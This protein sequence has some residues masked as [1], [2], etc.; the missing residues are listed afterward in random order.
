MNPAVPVE[1]GTVQTPGSRDDAIARVAEAYVW[2]LPLLLTRRTRAGQL[3]AGG[4]P[5]LVARDRLATA[6]DRA[7]VAPNNDTLYASG[8]FALAAG[9]V[10]VEAE[11]MAPPDRYWSVMLLDAYTHVAYVCRRLH[12][13]AGARV[14]VTYD[15][16]TPPVTDRGA[17]VLTLGTPTVWVLVRV[18]VDGPGDLDAARAALARIRVT[19]PAAA[20]PPV[21]TGRGDDRRAGV[22]R[23][24][25]AAVA[26]DPP[27]AW[28]PAPPAGLAA[29]LADPPPDDV[30][31]E[32]ARAG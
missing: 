32:G 12:G 3:T 18:L 26:E 27:A 13:R 23:E 21:G 1:R 29:L 14:R 2:G 24:L 7:V 22:L 20:A 8:W 6:A 17:D 19:G 5:G 11:A 9:D 4:G 16:A 15:S 28:H 25:A 30:V 31:A 10:T